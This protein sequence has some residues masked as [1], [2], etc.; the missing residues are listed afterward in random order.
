MH[1]LIIICIGRYHEH[2]ETLVFHPPSSKAAGTPTHNFLIISPFYMNDK[3]LP[4][5]PQQVEVTP[6]VRAVRHSSQHSQQLSEIYVV[7]YSF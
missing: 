6:D 1:K 5:I 2:T 3:I 4:G 7:S